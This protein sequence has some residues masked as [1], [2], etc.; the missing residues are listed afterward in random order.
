MVFKVAT[1]RDLMNAAGEPIFDPALFKILEQNP[2]ID[3]EWLPEDVTE[4]T[5]EIA[6][7]YDALHINL[8]RVTAASVMRGDCRVRI[9]ARNGVG[10][11]TVDLEAC[12]AKGIAVTNTPVAIQRPVAVAALTLVF[13]LSGKLFTKDR[14]VR[15][16][17]WNDR[18]EHM[19]IGLT[20]RTLGLIGAGGIG[21]ELI[22]LARPFFKEVKV[23][24]PYVAAD[25]LT[26]LGAGKVAFDEVLSTSDFLIVACPLNDE[27]RHL[28]NAEAFRQMK[29]TACFVNVAR[30]PIHDEAALVA[31]LSSGTIAAAGLDVTEEEP[32]SPESPLLTM[33]NTIITPHALCW[34]D[35]CFD[36][37]ARSALHSIL[38][39]SLGREPKYRVI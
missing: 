8:P 33:D 36:D 23:F 34:T 7:R 12:K 26:P 6:A 2:E 20:G 9:F 29:P 24:D 25:A 1:T 19:G 10:F 21:K 17:R 28:M 27:T 18:V 4:I 15:E 14:I 32:I 30:G 38:D 22:P 3:W 31:A 16:G 13:A 37:I 5:P 11:D 39:L 35:E